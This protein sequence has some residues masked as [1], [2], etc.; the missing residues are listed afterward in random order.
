M[1]NNDM[2]SRVRIEGHDGYLINTKSGT[3]FQ[4]SDIRNA[5]DTPMAC[6]E[7]MLIDLCEE[8]LKANEAS[9]NPRQP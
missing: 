8:L 5:W 7:Y 2:V 9:P 1:K 3:F 6:H 4:R